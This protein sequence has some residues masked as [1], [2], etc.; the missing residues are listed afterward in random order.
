MYL[1]RPRAFAQIFLIQELRLQNL[2]FLCR[3]NYVYPWMSAYITNWPV[4]RRSANHPKT[5]EQ[6]TAQLSSEDIADRKRL[7][8]LGCHA[9]DDG[10]DF[11]DHMEFAV[12]GGCI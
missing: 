7:S 8:A 10:Y 4:S 5:A 3:P 2:E 11:A 9:A 1:H 12:I 6:Q